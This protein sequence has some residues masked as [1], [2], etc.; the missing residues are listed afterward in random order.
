M[1][2]DLINNNS[3]LYN[4]SNLKETDAAFI[5]G[6]KCIKNAAEDLLDSYLEENG[7]AIKDAGQLKNFVEFL[8]DKIEDFES[9][10]IVT[11]IDSYKK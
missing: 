4:E 1:Y 6:I 5:N 7:I 11:V 2:K 10:F 8:E 9:E 3:D